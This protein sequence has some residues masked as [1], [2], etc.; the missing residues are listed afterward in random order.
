MLQE[1]PDS[2]PALHS[3]I[4]IIMSCHMRSPSVVPRCPPLSYYYVMSHEKPVSCPLLHPSCLLLCHL[5]GEAG[6]SS[7]AAPFLVIIMSCHMRSLS[8][9]PRCPPHVYYY[10]MSHEKPVSRPPPPP[11]CLLLCHVTGEAGQSS[12]A[13]PLMFIIMSCHM[14]SPSVV[15]RR[16][17]HV[18]YYVMLQEKP[19][20]RPPL[21]PS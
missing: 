3:V 5:T 7:P 21:P 16:P 17:P 13:A 4:S 2:R 1:K 11:S 10:V 6:Q 18:Y 19:V 9:I 15:P 14:R 8:V 20:S 12:P